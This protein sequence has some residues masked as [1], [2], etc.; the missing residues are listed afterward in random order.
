MPITRSEL[1]LV[2]A[3]TLTGFAARFTAL[4]ELAVEHF[5][6]GVY[7]SNLWFPDSGYAYPQ[8]HLYA[9]PLQPELIETCMLVFGEARWVPF[10]PSLLLGSL[11]IPL[12][13]LVVRRWSCGAA[14]VAAASLMALNDFHIAISRSA[15][16]DAP[17]VFFLLLSV[18]LISEALARVDL[19]IAIAAGLATGLTWATKYNG[20]LPIAIGVSGTL[21]AVLCLPTRHRNSTQAADSS[22]TPLLNWR[23]ALII[24]AVFVSVSLV[25]FFPVWSGLQHPPDAEQPGAAR[26]VGGYTA[27][28]QN[29]R[30]YVTGLSQWF[31]AAQRHEAVQRRYSGWPTLFGVWLAVASAALVIRAERSTWNAT[32][33]E[34][35][36]HDHSTTFMDRSTWNAERFKGTVLIAAA[37][38]SSLTCS[39]LFLI[40][41]WALLEFVGQ[42]LAHRRTG[43]APGDGASVLPRHWFAAW[44]GLAWLVGLA[45]ATPCYVAYPRLI[46]PLLTIGW[47]GTGMAINR[48]LTGPLLNVARTTAPASSSGDSPISERNRWIR[49]GWLTPIVFLALWQAAAREGLAWQVRTEL[50]DAANQALAAAAENCKD[51]DSGLPNARFVLYVYGEPGLFF[52]LPQDGVPVQPVTDLNF[53]LPGS[54]HARVP[55]FVLTGPNT[56]NDENF[57]GYMEAVSESLELVGVFP[58]RPSDFVLLDDHAPRDLEDHRAADVRLYRVRF[59]D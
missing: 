29:H 14:A 25:A 37:M 7:A 13:W 35:D 49:F 22:D 36:S 30:R 20:W 24:L 21:A 11:T 18:W 53:A 46:L 58:Y 15:L 42:I 26:Q 5:D 43:M 4:D 16:T 28:M 41:L 32:G 2:L 33:G 23:D 9:P 50:A 10:F 54:D 40:V 3:I 12:A 45:L 48:L 44:L 17:L 8:R 51:E 55:T 57:A 38:T 34:V 59:R 39:P 47:L 56:L 27:V 31:P 19:R 1:L 52:H 6:E